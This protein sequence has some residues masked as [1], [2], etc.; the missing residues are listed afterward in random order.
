MFKKETPIL[1][2]ALQT[3]TVLWEGGNSQNLK[4]KFHFGPTLDEDDE[5]KW[6][7]THVW[8]G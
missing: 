7:C 5:T 6:I 1:L 4:P 2:H 3:F 8:I